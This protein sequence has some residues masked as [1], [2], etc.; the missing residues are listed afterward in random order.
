M[1]S[2]SSPLDRAR[3]GCKDAQGEILER[4]RN[5]LLLLAQVG[6]HRWSLQGKA[7]A[8]DLVQETFSRAHRYF[9]RFRGT[10][11][12]ELKAWLRKILVSRLGKLVKKHCGAGRPRPREVADALTRS[13]ERLDAALVDPRD[14]P[15]TQASRREDAIRIA[16]AL[17]RIPAHYR[18]VV[19]L[20]LVEGLSFP[21]IAA[22]LGKTEDS[23]AKYWKRSLLLLAQMLGSAP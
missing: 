10:T 22:R 21:E 19:I 16:D 3:D 15:A 14:S 9:P 18:E 8:G 11:E 4:Y 20:R 17:A 1:T 7:D 13:S 23:V 2:T 6:L 5:Y 12:G